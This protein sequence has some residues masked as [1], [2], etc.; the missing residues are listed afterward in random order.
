MTSVPRPLPDAPR[1]ITGAFPDNLLPRLRSEISAIKAA[2][3][4]AGV[5]IVVSSE[6][7]AA[8]LSRDLAETGCNLA[9]AR[10][11]SLHSVLTRIN[12]AL[13]PDLRQLPADIDIPFHFNAMRNALETDNPFGETVD[14][15]GFGRAFSRSLRDLIEADISS[16]TMFSRTNLRQVVS[17]RVEV[18]SRALDNL[19]KSLPRE[20]QFNQID[21][22]SSDYD[23]ISSLKRA[24]H[25]DE[26]I[27]FGLYDFNELQFK[28][29]EF[30]IRIMPV[31]ML[32]PVVTDNG[33]AVE[34][35]K[36]AEGTVERLRET[37]SKANFEES[38][39]ENTISARLFDFSV[40]DSTT[41]TTSEK[42]GI[43]SASDP[44][45]ECEIIV[46]RIADLVFNRQ[47]A[48]HRI[49]IGL[50][51]PD[52]YAHLVLTQLKRAGLPF[53]DGIGTRLSK[54]EPGRAL[55]QILALTP[56]TISGRDIIGLLH[57]P[58][59]W[60]NLITEPNHLVSFERIINKTGVV[61][62]SAGAW[63][64]GLN[65]LV[66]QRNR[67]E[68]LE[69][70]EDDVKTVLD[71]VRCLLVAVNEISSETDYTA[72]LEILIKICRQMLKETPEREAII[73]CLAD[74]CDLPGSKM[75]FAIDDFR[76]II[77]SIL[78]SRIHGRGEP[79]SDGIAMLTP[80]TMRGIEF[81]YI[82]LP[83]FHQGGIPVVTNDNALLPDDLR[84]QINRV[85]SG[86]ET[87]PLALSVDRVSEDRLL[88]TMLIA[89]AREELSLSF[90]RRLFS[91]RSEQFPSQFILEYCRIVSGKSVSS[92]SLTS[93]SFYYDLSA[94]DYLPDWES[95][96]VQPSDY[97]RKFLST[98]NPLERQSILE[99]Y[100]EQGSQFHQRLQVAFD[101]HL[102][103]PVWSEFE[104]MPGPSLHTKEV[105]TI[106][107]SDLEGY[108]ECPL[109]Y[110]LNSGLK[111]TPWRE[112]EISLDV[113]ASILGEIIHEVFHKLFGLALTTGRIPLDEVDLPWCNEQSVIIFET[114][115][116]KYR[117]KCPAPTPIWDLTGRA[118]TERIKAAL[119]RLV[120]LQTG[121]R[122]E[123]SEIDL[124][125]ISL[126]ELFGI[127]TELLFK[128]RIDRLDKQSGGVGVH[129]IDYK[130]GKVPKPDRLDDGENLQ[131][132]LYLAA[133]LRSNQNLIL[134]NSAASYYQIKADGEVAVFSIDEVWLENNR[135]EL[136]SIL[137]SLTKCMSA[138]AFPPIPH[139]ESDCRNC[140]VEMAC[141]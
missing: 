123:A 38:G 140:A 116:P 7:S 8:Y 62:G 16:L 46:G 70:N 85:I 130:T 35:F 29:L 119:P 19:G 93:L 115:I 141:D 133:V 88:F 66:N 121:L 80:L 98:L 4:L 135:A 6:V 112:P 101:S 26:I 87:V 67:D 96:L 68:E 134:G 72:S 92:D 64:Q 77:S 52:E 20:F 138:R 76:V 10:I 34:A 122:F 48:P 59:I 49:A 21:S 45:S 51:S 18:I 79:I 83:G 108:A 113:S 69:V 14:Y 36:F 128:G 54:T 15:P 102:S 104:G 89:S 47:V 1:L 57:L 94:G 30:L 11:L 126:E 3:P 71:F 99:K 61:K 56:G 91:A 125:R 63:E 9:N 44:A 65:R 13:H 81:D 40:E 33:K 25:V 109:R 118:L 2:D 95:R 105:K 32:L 12:S 28:T 24:I 58:S 103:G 86:R 100:L 107:V 39:A 90:P 120:E 42:V 82:F 60:R 41:P 127:E 106:S 50:W 84:Q 37:F 31:T 75:A 22:N 17:R 132:P 136:S 74:Q 131:L 110:W 23:L 53:Y 5:A 97:L 124:E 27:F 114:L 43:F 111:L 78:D 73:E 117:A 129:I 139:N 55:L 137:S